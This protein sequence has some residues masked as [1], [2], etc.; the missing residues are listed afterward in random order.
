MMPPLF[1]RLSPSRSEKV[2]MFAACSNNVTLVNC[3]KNVVELGSK[4]SP[5]IHHK[6]DEVL[7]VVNNKDPPEW[8]VSLLD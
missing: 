6:I 4:Y 7:E 1:R 3:Y 5:D 2:D 8:W